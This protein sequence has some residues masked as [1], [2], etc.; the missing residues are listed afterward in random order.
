MNIRIN[1]METPI[2]FSPE[3]LK[4]LQSQLNPT[5][6]IVT[7]NGV[8]TITHSNG[9]MEQFGSVDITL[10]GAGENEGNTTITLPFGTLLDVQVTP[11]DTPSVV[12]E[13]AHVQIL[14]D[15]QVRIY[16]HA[17]TPAK[18]VTVRYSAKGLI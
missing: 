10:S 3:T 15:S 9:L 8:T 1:G 14:S 5:A 4:E 7:E 18:K 12:G 2:E 17:N 11:T 13:T 6:D 16:G